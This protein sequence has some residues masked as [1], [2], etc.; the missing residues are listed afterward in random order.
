MQSEFQTAGFGVTTGSLPP[1]ADA[2]RIT[3][4]LRQCGVIS[5]AS[6]YSVA[7]VGS[8]KK[9]RSHTFRLRLEYKGQSAGAPD[10][11]ILKNGHLDSAG[12]STYAN[13]REIAFYREVS[14]AA[15]IG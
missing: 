7:A 12:R 9:L 11:I 6:V 8:L 13:R 5:S 15:S 14:S 1:A 2:E 10:T 3:E 4:A